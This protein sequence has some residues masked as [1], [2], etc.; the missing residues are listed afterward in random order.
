MRQLAFESCPSVVIPVSLS[1][2]AEQQSKRNSD[3]RIAI[4]VPKAS[5]TAGA[6]RGGKR[7]QLYLWRARP[8]ERPP[9]SVR[10][11][12]RTLRG[13]V[14][15]SHARTNF[16]RA[17]LVVS[18][19]R[20]RLLRL[21]IP[22]GQ[23]VGFQFVDQGLVRYAQQPR[24]RAYVSVSAGQGLGDD[25]GLPALQPLLEGDVGLPRIC[26][27]LILPSKAVR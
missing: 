16:V 20:E 3:V 11:S 12:S 27:A 17:A 2:V 22:L 7:R 24:G 8:G 6:K 5:A 10:I 18:L 25:T 13:P 26:A 1:P 14:R 21:R 23:P 15:I 19:F 9:G 4:G